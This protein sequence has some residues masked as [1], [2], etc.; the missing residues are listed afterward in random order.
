MLNSEVKIDAPKDAHSYILFCS[1]LLENDPHQNYWNY[2]ASSV[3]DSEL[4]SR[5][6]SQIEEG[7]DERYQLAID[8][9]NYQKI[10]VD[11][12]PFIEQGIEKLQQFQSRSPELVIG[13]LST[14]AQLEKVNK[15][16]NKRLK[17]LVQPGY[18]LHLIHEVRKVPE[19]VAWCLFIYL[20]F[21]P[22]AAITAT[23]GHAQNGFDFLNNTV[24]NFSDDSNDFS[25]ESKKVAEMFLRIIVQENY[26]DDLL[27]K[28]WE[29]SDNA[30]EW[31]SYCIELAINQGLSTQF[32][33]PWEVV[34]RWQQF[35]RNSL[36][37]NV[38]KVLIS[39]QNQDGKLVAYLI[40][41]TE[42]DPSIS[43]LYCQINEETNYDSPEFIV[44]CLSGLQSLDEASWQNQLKTS[45]VSLRLAINL[46]ER[47]IDVDLD[48]RFSDAYAEHANLMLTK[49]LKVDEDLIEHWQKLPDLLKEDYARSVL[50]KK[51]VDKA[52]EANGTISSMYFELYGSMIKDGIIGGTTGNRYDYVLRLFTPLLNSNNVDGL[53]WIYEL[54]D[55]N[56]TLLAT[57][58]E[59]DEVYDF[60][61]RL[62][63]KAD[64][65][66]S[67]NTSAEIVELSEAILNIIS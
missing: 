52:L 4:G 67:S 50:H 23:Q 13:I 33:I 63:S 60:K 62:K 2:F 1:Y 16:V 31:I 37:D 43:D 54:L 51:I 36:T 53:N 44:W 21:Q 25:A 11:W 3:V 34:N 45:G 55:E 49:N 47:N 7:F 19:A 29:Q 10:A 12:N 38:L 6:V 65:E 9:I 28:V 22:S 39:E 18:I 48:Q 40:G 14:C 5:Y 59:K 30:K 57:Y 15:E 27:F 46:N 66:E 8:V 32:I 24:F 56:P 64:A 35:Y 42:F 17:G 58:S 26:L 41:E 61:T 20:R